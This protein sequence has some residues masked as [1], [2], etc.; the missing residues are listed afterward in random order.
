MPR[1][2]DRT[3]V[4]QELGITVVPV[5]VRFGKEVYRDGIDI[6]HEELYQKLSVV[7]GFPKFPEDENYQRSIR[8]MLHSLWDDI[9]SV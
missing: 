5:Y 3:E 7:E 6:S 4:A 8:T 2:A 9:S 1:P